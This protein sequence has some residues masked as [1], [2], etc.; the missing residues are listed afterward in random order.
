MDFS[1]NGKAVVSIRLHYWVNQLVELLG[2]QEDALHGAPQVLD[3]QGKFKEAN[4]AQLRMNAFGLVDDASGAAAAVEDEPRAG[5]KSAATASGSGRGGRGASKRLPRSLLR[6]VSDR[7]CLPAE[8][9][10][11]RNIENS[12][13]L[14]AT[15][16]GPGAAGAAGVVAAGGAAA[17]PAATSAQTSS[18]SCGWSRT[19]ASTR[20]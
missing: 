10:V 15:L 13:R 20:S 17:A 2:R 7:L 12:T 18:R 6:S 5:S 14:D 4:F 3:E 11:W 19:D 8:R 9:R 1:F 16:Q